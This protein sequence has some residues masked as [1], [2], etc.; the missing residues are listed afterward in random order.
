M[1]LGTLF[2]APIQ[3]LGEIGGFINQQNNALVAS[4]STGFHREH[5]VD[6]THST[7]HASGKIYERG[8]VEPVA[9][10]DT[11]P[12]FLKASDFTGNGTQTWTISGTAGATEI[13]YAL[14]GSQMRL[15]F[16]VTQTTVGGGANT[17][18]LI[19]IPGGFYPAY[20][21]YNLCRIVDNNVVA[22]GVAFVAPGTNQIQIQRND[23]AN[24]AASVALTSVQGQLWFETRT[25]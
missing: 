11:Q 2:E 4:I 7:I 22:V 19:K 13:R 20:Q 18:L 15:D 12:V 5:N 10:G 9:L 3:A 24:W 6:D 23:S 25:A 16:Y 8:R 17:R 1:R 21:A 14:V